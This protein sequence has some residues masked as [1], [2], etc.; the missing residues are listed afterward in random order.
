[1]SDKFVNTNMDAKL[2]KML[3]E[4]VKADGVDRS[5]FIRLLVKREWEKR[6]PTPSPSPNIRQRAANYLERGEAAA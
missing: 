5:K 2:V 4:M 1:M 3:D 6:N